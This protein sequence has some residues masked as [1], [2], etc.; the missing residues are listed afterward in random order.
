MPPLE[1]SQEQITPDE[2]ISSIYVK[3]S[4][5]TNDQFD[6]NPDTGLYE[7]QRKGEPHIDADT[8]TVLTFANVIVLSTNITSYDGGDLREVA[9]NGGEGWFFTGGGMENITWSKNSYAEQFSFVKEDGSP[10]QGNV[11]PTFIA[12]IDESMVPSMILTE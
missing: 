12:L 6:Y 5:Y 8:G 11:G 9:L 1:I 4:G 3:F 2:K 7:K 10:I